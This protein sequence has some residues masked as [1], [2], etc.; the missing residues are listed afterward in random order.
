MAEFIWS[1]AGLNVPDDWEP[2]TLER[3]GLLLADGERPVC[4][5]KWRTVQGTFSFDKHLKRLARGH[6]GVDVRPVADDEPPPSW[7]AAVARLRGSGIAS[8]SFIWQSGGH[9]GIGAAL[10]NPATGLAAL[11]QFFIAEEGEEERAAA[12]LATFRDV[13]GG[14]TVP[15]AMFG[16]RGRVP[17]GFG[18]ETFAFRPGHYSIRYWKPRKPDPSSRMPAGKGAGTRLTFERF[19]PASVLLKETTLA[20]WVAD[21]FC[22]APPRGLAMVEAEGRVAWDGVAK[23]SLLRRL[24]RRELHARG[25]GW[26]P[27]D[28]NAILVV[29]ATGAVPLDA[30][31]F[32][33][34]VE[35]YELV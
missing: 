10:H 22:E 24:L 25:R 28:A 33:A 4:E 5:V 1:G 32:A 16:L 34:T 21:N 11:I 6:R 35:A 9:R 27:D 8:R 12:I 14:R 30:S 19:V 31:A 17:A 2:A 20:R 26:T 3:D 23:T 7:V 29:A 15:F 13:S 18:L